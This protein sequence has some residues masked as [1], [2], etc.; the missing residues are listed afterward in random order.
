MRR[1]PTNPA[2]SRSQPAYRQVA[3]LPAS[4]SM[5]TKRNG[6]WRSSTVTSCMIPPPPP[7]SCIQYWLDRGSG[8]SP[9]ALYV[10]QRDVCFCSVHAV[11]QDRDSHDGREARTTTFVHPSGRY[12]ITHLPLLTD[13]AFSFLSQE[14]TVYCPFQLSVTFFYINFGFLGVLSP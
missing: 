3:L 11:Y 7:Q 4:L 6:C 9:I 2:S 12:F 1:G 10:W 8:W 13:A 5:N 14:N